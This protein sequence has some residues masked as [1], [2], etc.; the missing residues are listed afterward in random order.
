MHN[1]R[2]VIRGSFYDSQIY[3][4]R[5][6]LWTIEGSIVTIDWERLIESIKVEDRLKL[7]LNC[8]FCRSEYL[9]SADFKLLFQN[10]EI[11]NILIKQFYDISQLLFVFSIDDL[12]KRSLVINEEKNPLPFPHSDSYIYAR[13]IYAGNPSGISSA[14]L[15]KLNKQREKLSTSR[16]LWDGP[17]LNLSAA[18]STLAIASGSEGFFEL[19]LNLNSPNLGP[20]PRQVSSNHSTFVRWMYASVFSSSYLDSGYLAY[21]TWKDSNNQNNI[22]QSAE[23]IPVSLEIEDEL[24]ALGEEEEV[25]ARK[26]KKEKTRQLQEIIPSRSIF[27]GNY[28]EAKEVY[29]WGSSDKFC[30]I[31]QGQLNVIKYHPYGKVSKSSHD[32]GKV[33]D[34]RFEPFG[35]IGGE[36]LGNIRADSVI[37]ADSAVFGFVIEFEDGLFVVPSDVNGYNFLQ[38]E[39]V[40]WRVF[41]KSKY[42]TNQLHVVYEDYFCVYSFNDDY[43]VDQKKKQAGIQ[44]RKLYIPS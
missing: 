12:H 37:S 43:F 29:T 3:A 28:T 6:Y 31:S 15:L 2:L 21:S 32:S 9:Y 40:N 8:A 16:K 38:G 18:Y 13:S 30:L 22:A 14:Q 27:G 41:P 1:L 42:Y 20:E 23:E 7:A 36:S 33:L 24:I 26:D 17:A 35:S 5:L 39:P 11:R 4:G 19:P 44:L 34:K 25:S 10:E